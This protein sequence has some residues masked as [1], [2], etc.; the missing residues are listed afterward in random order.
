VR[1]AV[2]G[3]TGLV[4]RHAM[5][6][7]HHAGHTPITIARSAGT[8]LTT[9]EGLDE[10][11]SGVAAVIDVTNTAAM[12]PAE[13]EK[14]FR[15]VTGNLLAAEEHAGVR[16]HLVL[17]IVG[18]DRVAGNAHYIG[19]RLQE[20]LVRQSRIPATIVRSTQFFEFAEMVVRWTRREDRAVVP[21]LLYQPVAVA[22]VAGLLAELTADG[23]R[24]SFVEVAG[25]EP[26]DLV[27]VARRVLAARGERL[28]LIPSWHGPFGADMAGDVLLP[29]PGTRIAP[30]TLEQWL[31]ADPAVLP[32]ARTSVA[33]G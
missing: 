5:A 23:P 30:T 29:G 10:A 22:D 1:V 4:G 27:D 25:P 19:K 21:P 8:D 13:A 20:H 31:A 6:A 15:T 3:G 32:P 24:D 26:Q 14:F 33:P 2:A 9:A 11:L 17:S 28:R 12:D 7:L 16:H 18:L